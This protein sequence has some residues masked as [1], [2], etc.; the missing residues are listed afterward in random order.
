MKLFL[1]DC[2]QIKMGETIMFTGQLPKNNLE[3]TPKFIHNIFKKIIL[4]KV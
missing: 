4:K 2:C 1:R 3:M